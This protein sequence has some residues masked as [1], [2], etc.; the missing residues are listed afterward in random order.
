MN[1]GIPKTEGLSSVLSV[2]TEIYLSR[3]S[4]L[5]LVGIHLWFPFGWI[6]ADYLRG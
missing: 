2:Q 1:M 6:P 4:R 5:L 3:H